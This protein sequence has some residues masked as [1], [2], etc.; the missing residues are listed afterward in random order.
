MVWDAN[1]ARDAT[2]QIN[3]LESIVPHDRKETALKLF[4]E[5]GYQINGTF[6]KYFRCQKCSI[7]FS[8]L[9]YPVLP[10]LYL[11]GTILSKVMQAEPAHG[12]NWSPATKELFSNS[13]ARGGKKNFTAVSKRL[14]KNA[15]DCQVRILKRFLSDIQICQLLIYCI[16]Q[17]TGLLLLS[18]QGNK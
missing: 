6:E 8:L 15:G 9:F 4:H 3:L 10:Y 2:E 17:T 12:L 16:I 5:N 1:K 18:L 7:L 14:K 11:E 13:I